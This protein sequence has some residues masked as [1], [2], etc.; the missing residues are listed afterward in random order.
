VTDHQ[1]LSRAR[2]E[3]MAELPLMIR[4]AWAMPSP[5]TFSVPPIGNFVRRWLTGTS[6][7]P[8][9]R[10]SR[11]ATV[12]ND[13][14]P[15]TLADYHLDAGEFC[16][17]MQGERRRFD[18]A[19][20]DPPYSPRQISEVYQSIGREVTGKDTQNAALYKRVRDA[21]DPLIKPGGVVL[22]F[23]WN[24]AGMGRGRGYELIDMLVVCH[25]GGHNDTICIAERKERAAPS[26]FDDARAA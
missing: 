5:D 11:L 9:A 13:L 3:T 16:L 26:L 25:G 12:Q 7:D 15:D 17:L 22:S 10:N 18:S 2:D 23:G 14:N 1:T 4:R 19:L 8:F 6:I 20:F 21:L 24:S